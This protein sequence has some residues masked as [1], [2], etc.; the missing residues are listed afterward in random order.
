MLLDKTVETFPHEEQFFMSYFRVKA[1]FLR[2]RRHLNKK[3]ITCVDMG[4]F[5]DSFDIIFLNKFSFTI[6]LFDDFVGSRLACHLNY[7]IY[8]E[9]SIFF[10]NFS[11]IDLNYY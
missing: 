6:K 5:P 10:I 3:R 1:V 7:Q 2:Q 11:L 4:S 9:R 8:K